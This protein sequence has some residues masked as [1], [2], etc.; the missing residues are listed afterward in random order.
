MSI[1][2]QFFDFIG[3]QNEDERIGHCDWYCCAVGDFILAQTG[4][5]PGPGDDSMDELLGALEEEEGFIYETLNHGSA[6]WTSDEE[7]DIHTYGGLAAYIHDHRGLD[8][9]DYCEYEAA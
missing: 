1:V 9:D 2:E 7:Y 5:R 8:K 4:T 6:D 3:H